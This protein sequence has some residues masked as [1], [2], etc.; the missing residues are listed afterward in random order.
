MG[1]LRSRSPAGGH[2][3]LRRR[4]RQN[5]AGRGAPSAMFLISCVAAAAA[6]GA[7]LAAEPTAEANVSAPFAPAACDCDKA[8]VE[9]SSG[10]PIWISVTFGI[11]LL[12]L[13]G[14]FSGL[15]LG[16]LGLD[17]IALHAIAEA[18]LQQAD[19]PNDPHKAEKEKANADKKAA[20]RIIPL[21]KK[22]NRLLCTLLLG[23]VMVNVMI[24]ILLADLTGGLFGFI[25]STVFIVIFGEIVPQ[26]TCSRYAL[27]IGALSIPLVQFFQIILFPLTFPIALALDKCLGQDMG[28][29]Y[30]NAQLQQLMAVHLQQGLLAQRES[31]IIERGLQM[32]RTSVAD[33]MTYQK[34]VYSLK[35]DEVLTEAKLIEIWQKGHSRIPVIEETVSE[36]DVAFADTRSGLRPPGPVPDEDTEMMSTGSPNALGVGA[37]VDKRDRCIGILYTKDLI[38]VRDEDRLTVRDVLNFYSRGQPLTIDKSEKLD[39]VLDRFRKKKVHLALVEEIQFPNKG[40]P[41]PERVGIVT[42]EDVLEHLV[43][44]EFVDEH[45]VVEDVSAQ[46]LKKTRRHNCPIIA[47]RTRQ[48]DLSL[49]EACAVANYLLRTIPDAFAHLAFQDM[50]HLVRDDTKYK[51]ISGFRQG[52]EGWAVD[53]PPDGCAAWIYRKG[54]P[55]TTFTFIL[56][57]ELQVTSGDED[58]QTVLGP[59]R[60]LG[61]RALTMKDTDK[62][63]KCDFDC[64]VLQSDVRILQL[65]KS[66]LARLMRHARG[67]RST[68]GQERQAGPIG[69]PGRPPSGPRSP[70]A[71]EEGR[72]DGSRRRAPSLMEGRGDGSTPQRQPRPQQHWDAQPEA[73]ANLTYSPQTPGD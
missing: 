62:P 25:F 18:P 56:A 53:R 26:A 20:Q 22:G 64:R 72:Q 66:D 48:G 60:C 15:T 55:L 5:A 44:E 38:T 39:K 36:Q 31:T 63:L 19:G 28:Q 10:I 2:G 41:R 49:D 16:L 54:Q 17:S 46:Q 32:A 23:N 61:V 47:F 35:A 40:D 51:F 7:A 73:P 70:A 50:V 1:P 42:L 3:D 57:G 45:D 33:I 4:R 69:S 71:D 11:I 13:S 58:F 65:E 14:C 29:L 67:R 6:A 59:Y 34:N 52:C 21:R 8:P 9:E 68:G 12:G 27:Q 24:P 37:V 30:D 43:G